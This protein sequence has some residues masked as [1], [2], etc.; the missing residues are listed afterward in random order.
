MDGNVT[1]YNYTRQQSLEQLTKVFG[2]SSS[3]TI[4]VNVTD[5]GIGG[6]DNLLMLDTTKLVTAVP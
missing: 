1:T 6:F 3:E 5:P 2:S 4:N